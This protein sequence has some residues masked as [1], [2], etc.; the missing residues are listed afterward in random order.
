MKKIPY[1][2]SY[3]LC[4]FF[5]ISTA[6]ADHMMGGDLAYKC[7]G[8]GK[9]LVTLKAYRDCNG[10]SLAN[11]P[12]VVVPIGSSGASMTKA[13]AL[14]SITDITVLCS[15]SQV[16]KCAGGTYPY[17]IEEHVFR[18]TL[19]LSAYTGCKFRISWEQSARSGSITTGMAN[20]NFYIEAMLDKCLSS[21]NNSPQFTSPPN[22]ILC[23]GMD[24]CFDHGMIEPDG[25]SVSYSLTDA[26]QY[27]GS[28]CTY[29]S[30]YNK[31]RPLLFLGAPNA[32][33]SLPGGFHLDAVSAELCFRPTKVEKGVVVVKA[34]EWRNI[35]GVMTNIGETRRDVMYIVSACSN[36]NKPPVI[37]SPLVY[38]ACAGSQLCFL[39][40]AN[41]FN[42]IDT[43]RLRWNNGIPG[44]TFTPF[45]P[46]GSRKQRA[47]FCW[48]PGDSDVRSQPYNFTANAKDNFCPQPAI[49]NKV[50]SINVLPRQKGAVRIMNNMGCGKV[51]FDAVTIDTGSAVYKWTIKNS[52]A[53]VVYDDSLQNFSH[54]FSKAGRYYVALEVVR[55]GFCNTKYQDTL[56]VDPFLSVALP[57]D[58]SLCRG[59]SLQISSAVSSGT[60]PYRYQW[61]SSIADTFNVLN[62]SVNSS[63][64]YLL[65]VTDSVNCTVTDTI[66]VTARFPF[67]DAGPDK[68]VCELGGLQSLSGSPAAGSWSGTGVSGN[69]FNPSTAGTGFHPLIYLFTDSTGCSNRDTM[70]MIVFPTPVV[71]AGADTSVCNNGIL[72]LSGSP[73]NGSW[74]GPGV[75]GIM[76]DPYALNAG[77][78]QLAYEYT[79]AMGCSAKDSMLVNVK[80]LPAVNAG[81][82]TTLCEDGKSFLLYGTPAGGN[83]SGPGIS[84]NLFDPAGFSGAKIITY[85]FT[86]NNN[87]TDTDNREVLVNSLPLVNAG[88]DRT[89]CLDG[90]NISLGGSPVT[91]VWSGPG[92][93]AGIFNPST[94]GRGVHKA[95]LKATN[96]NGCSAYDSI[97]ISVVKP[98]ADFSATPLIGNGPLTVG[99]TDLSSSSFKKLE[100]N[101]GDPSSIL[102][103]SNQS[104]PV[105][106]YTLK[107]FYTVTLITLDTSIAGCN[108]T[109]SKVNYVEVTDWGIGLSEP[110]D[111]YGIKAFPNPA[112][113][114]FD[115]WV[116]LP[117]GA[118]CTLNMFDIGGKKVS[119]IREVKKGTLHINCEGL[120]AGMYF[121]EVNVTNGDIY[122]S[123]IV[124]E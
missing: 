39:I 111:L 43:V 42:A 93:A 77:M 76:F 35:N 46:S 32:N 23:V 124:L 88:S 123:K 122:R 100:W 121:L 60:L 68:F 13:L 24:Y 85:T 84:G 118:E 71:S 75:T 47:T 69:N 36:T 6:F 79:D 52:T 34:T 15:P 120:N 101:F 1:L 89:V 72:L 11:S 80:P 57:S 44:A 66:V 49:D 110:A 18:D 55:P 26:M 14:I 19:D 41:D 64:S 103:I 92:I 63:A 62:L 86:D 25:D 98:V 54:S 83:W 37:N 73:A 38:D 45:F 3:F 29:A 4:C 21:C 108:D 30:G 91:G 27:A 59:S 87:C 31:D 9:Y 81:P 61:S 109:L 82:D 65:T 56:D 119:Q 2:L 5:M 67:T 51:A 96:A 74:S 107:G 116:N 115:L 97:I 99:F 78:H 50:F 17:G 22:P 53:V 104:A 106:V 16:S 113:K 102:N 70:T 48:T 8:N 40:N 10:I 58:T 33:V 12:I 105:H 90:V 114:S 117:E 95:L 94:A 112:T 20:Q 7:L 28:P